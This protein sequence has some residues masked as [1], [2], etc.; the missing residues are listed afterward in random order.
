MSDFTP[1]TPGYRSPTETGGWAVEVYNLEG[2]EVPAFA[3]VEAAGFEQPEPGRLVI[4]VQKP[5]TYGAQYRHWINGPTP[6]KPGEFGLCSRAAVRAAYDDGDGTPQPGENWGPVPG[7]WKLRK[8]SGGFKVLGKF[9]NGSEV[10]VLPAPLLDVRCVLNDA[11]AAGGSAEAEVH[12]DDGATGHTIEVYDLLPME[13][14]FELA[15][16]TG[17]LAR[18]FEDRGKWVA[19]AAETC[20]TEEEEED[21]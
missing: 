6:I 4:Q 18:W 8:G 15:S 1:H 2:E 20:P 3:V 16:G 13:S 21:E 9:D 11:L 19:M 5:T 10:W 7:E 12:D 17:V 14:G